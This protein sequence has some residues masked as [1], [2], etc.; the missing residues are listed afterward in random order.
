MPL[1]GTMFPIFMVVAFMCTIFTCS[2]D[3][4]MDWSLMRPHARHKFLR[5]NLIYTNSVPVYYF[6]MV[7][8]LLDILLRSTWLWYIPFR[9]RGLSLSARGFIFGALEMLRRVQWNFY[10]VENEHLGNMDQYRVTREVPLPYSR[11]DGDEDDYSGTED[12]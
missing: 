12:L 7:I 4:L 2:W 3:L 8:Q 10:R 5:Q 1:H 9:S 11:D 6:S